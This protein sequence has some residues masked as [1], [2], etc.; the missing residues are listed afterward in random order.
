MASEI[1]IKGIF[2]LL[3]VPVVLWLDRGA[4]PRSPR[5][6]SGVLALL[7][8]L[9]AAAWFNFGALH[10]PGWIHHWE[11]FHYVLGSKYYPELG[12]DGLYAASLA[13][14]QESRPQTRPPLWVRD[15]RS[16]E[17]VLFQHL[18]P[19][20]QEVKARFTPARW[21]RF[22]TDHA[23]FVDNLQWTYFAGIRRDHGYNPPPTW[24]FTARLASAWLPV[25]AD[26]LGLLGVLDVLLLAVLFGFLFR[27]YGSRVCCLCLVV[28]GLGYA[29]RFYWIGGAFLRL[30]WLAALGVAVCMMKRERY[31][32]AGGLVAYAAMVRIFPVL[33][34]LGPAVLAV[35]ALVRKEDLGWAWR[36]AQGLLLGLVLCL[37]AGSLTG[38]GVDAWGDFAANLDKHHGTW[39]TNNVGLAN[40]VLYDLDTVTRKDVNFALPEPWLRW[41]AKMDRLLEARRPWIWA[42]AGLY[43]LLVAAAAWRAERDQSLVLGLGAVFALTLLTCYYWAMLLLVPLRGDRRAA[44]ALLLLSATLCGV[45]LATPPSF[46]MVFGVMS[47]ALALLLLAW[48]A[49]SAVATLRAALPARRG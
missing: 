32:W 9:A 14:Q 44:A 31:R 43:L 46:E 17:V 13:A 41:Q 27:T 40:V 38:R 4:P 6:A 16:N 47:W 23:Y 8:A 49:P 35:R 25:E 15:L 36:F 22:K 2:C 11:Q 19:H 18:M 39:L 12:H 33:V 10:G 45:H 24:T 20:G 37:A 3:A 1:W 29:W 28:F 21:E 5:R 30:D 34:L 26:T 42:L 48:T 7:A